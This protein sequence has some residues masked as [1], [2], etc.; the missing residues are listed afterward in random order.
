MLLLAIEASAGPASVAVTRDG[1]IIARSWQNNGLTHSRTLMPMLEDMMKNSELKLEDLDAVAVSIGPGSFTGLRIGVA[2]TKGI[3]WALNKPCIPVS[4][5]EA[6]AWNTAHMD[7]IICP[8]MD[9]RRSQVYNALFKAENGSI[10]RICE[11]RA[12]SVSELEVELRR[13]SERII[14]VGDGAELCLKSLNLPAITCA[15]AQLVYQDAVGVALGAAH[16]RPVTA[17]ELSASYIRL[18]QAER[19][20]LEKTKNI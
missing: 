6:M 19:E 17:A 11:D 1:R 8:V 13:F 12:V 3:A 9:A 4:T 14:L 15:P 7:G 18:P 5:L 10:T 16:S 20:R 2:T